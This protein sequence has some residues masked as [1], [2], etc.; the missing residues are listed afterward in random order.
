[1]TPEI[2]AS[3]IFTKQV[4]RNVYKLTRKKVI[5][6]LCLARGYFFYLHWYTVPSLSYI[7]NILT[8]EDFLSLKALKHQKYP[9]YVQE[10]K[11]TRYIKILI[12]MKKM[13]ITIIITIKLV[14]QK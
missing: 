3:Y 9:K 5:W 10:K 13:H 2:N 6:P 4:I 12:T 1:M 8:Q 11:S 7:Q 14:K